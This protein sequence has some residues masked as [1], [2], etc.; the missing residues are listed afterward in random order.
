MEVVWFIFFSLLA[1]LAG[2]VAFIYFFKQG[3]FDDPEDPKYHLFRE[4][5]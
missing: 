3:Q 1:G 4:D 2:L 5:E